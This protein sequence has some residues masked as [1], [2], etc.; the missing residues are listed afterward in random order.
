M[1]C[2]SFDTNYQK[3]SICEHT[4]LDPEEIRIW[5]YYENRKLKVLRDPEK[6]L[7][8]AQIL[9]N[10]NI[11]VEEISHNEICPEVP[12]KDPGVLRQQYNNLQQRYSILQ[13][14]NQ[15]QIAFKEQYN[16]LATKFN[17]VQGESA[18]KLLELLQQLTPTQT[19]LLQYQPASYEENL[20]ALLH[21]T[22]QRFVGETI[23]ALIQSIEGV[24][25]NQVE[26]LTAKQKT[27]DAA[28]QVLRYGCCVLRVVG[29]AYTN[30]FI[31]LVRY[32]KILYELLWRLCSVIL[33]T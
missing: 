9:H 26:Q 31:G 24:I 33:I 10:Q 14:K 32:L 11:L 2:S 19:K 30:E 12:S 5:D 15:Q 3:E 28:E 13:R 7:D 20:T 29:F 21:A 1:L 4:K 25:K 23:H 27:K 22:S 6:S 8:E 16:N 18:I 17:S